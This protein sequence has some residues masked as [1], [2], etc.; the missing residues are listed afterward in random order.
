MALTPYLLWLGLYVKLLPTNSV[1]NSDTIINQ[2][3]TK[4]PDWVERE[5]EEEVRI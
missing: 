4:K 3:I 2:Y 5:K 1:K